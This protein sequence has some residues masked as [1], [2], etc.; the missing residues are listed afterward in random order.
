M[1]KYKPIPV[2]LAAILALT[3]AE[4]IAQFSIDGELGTTSTG[5]LDIELNVSNR[6]NFTVFVDPGREMATGTGDVLRSADTCLSMNTGGGYSVKVVTNHDAFVLR[7]DTLGEWIPFFAYWNDHAGLEG[8]QQLTHGVT[9]TGL[10]LDEAQTKKCLEGLAPGNS[11]FSI[12]IPQLSVQHA[13]QAGY[14]A[15]ISL[16]VAPE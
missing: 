2:L 7:N 10:A 8:R 11:N 4:C 9:L 14:G 13:R 12:V 3:A 16:I 5:K 15:T 6:V 1:K